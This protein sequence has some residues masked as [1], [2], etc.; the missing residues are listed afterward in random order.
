MKQMH[1]F[2]ITCLVTIGVVLTSPAASDA[3]AIGRPPAI[4]DEMMEEQHIQYQ[5]YATYVS[6]SLYAQMK[7]LEE[8]ENK[9]FDWVKSIADLSSTLFSQA[10]SLNSVLN[11]DF[12]NKELITLAIGTEL[13]FLNTMVGNEISGI[14]LDTA[15]AAF[16]THQGDLSAFAAYFSTQ[17][18][19]YTVNVYGAIQFWELRRKIDQATALNDLM[20]NYYAFGQDLDAIIDYYDIPGSGW[21]GIVQ[22]VS[23]EMDVDKDELYDDVLLVLR[24]MKDFYE[25][26][27]HYNENTPSAPGFYQVPDGINPSGVRF[28][29]GASSCEKCGTVKYNLEIH[30]NNRVI[31][32]ADE[33]LGHLIQRTSFT[34]PITLA[35]NTIYDWAVFPKSQSGNWNLEIGDFSRFT[36]GGSTANHLPSAAFFVSPAMGDPSTIFSFDASDSR[37][38]DGDSLSYQWRW[39]T[40]DGFVTSGMTATH[41]YAVPG[42]YTVTLRVSD[43]TADSYFSRNI[44][45]T[46]PQTPPLAPIDPNPGRGAVHQPIEKSITWSD[47][48][49]ADTYAVYFGTDTD[50]DNN[51]KTAVSNSFFDP[52]PLA[53]NTTYFWRVDA[54]NAHGTTLGDTWYFTTQSPPAWLF[55]HYWDFDTSGTEGWTPRNAQSQGIYNQDYWIIDPSFDPASKSGI[56]SAPDLKSLHTGQYGKIEVRAAV[57]NTYLDRLEAHLKIDD[58]WQPPFVLNYVSGRQTANSQCLYQGDIPYAGAIQQVRIDFVTGSD[59][60]DD[61]VYID[62]V[63]F[64]ERP[65]PLMHAISGYVTNEAGEGIPGVNMAFSNGAGTVLTN[66]AGYYDQN[67][68]EGWSGTV[69]P[70][71]P[72]Y[73]FNPATTDYNNVLFPQTKNYTGATTADITSKIFFSGTDTL[74]DGV[75]FNHGFQ[76]YSEIQAASAGN[77][78]TIPER[79]IL[80]TAGQDRADSGEY[81]VYRTTIPFDTSSLPE[82]AVITSAT[83]YLYGYDEGY[84][85]TDFDLQVVQAHPASHA[86]LVTADYSQFGAIPGGTLN[87]ATWQGHNGVNPIRLNHEGI[88]WINT[89]GITNLGLRSNRDINQ[90][91]PEEHG[92]VNFWS[93]QS[94]TDYR[95]VLAVE[96]EAPVVNAPEGIQGR[97]LD[98]RTQ[99]TIANAQVTAGSM[100]VQSNDNGQYLLDLG[101]GEYDVTVSR[102]G[103]QTITRTN[104]QVPDNTMVP[105]DIELPVSLYGI[106]T[107]QITAEPVMNVDI[108]ASSQTTKSNIRG[109]YTLGSLVPGIY[110]ILFDKYDHLPVTIPDVEIIA[111]QS[112]ELNVELPVALAGTVTDYA[113][114]QPISNVI[115]STINGKSTQTNPRGRYG[116]GAFSPGVYDITFAKTGYQTVTIENVY[117]SG[118][119]PVIRDMRMTLPGPL[120]IITPELPAAETQNPYNPLVRISGGTPPYTFTLSAGKIPPGCTLDA[121][122]GNITGIP[123]TPG[124]YTFSIRVMDA[125]GAYAERQ[126]SIEVTRPLV[127]ETDARLPDATQD[128]LYQTGI[129]ASGGTRPYHF[130]YTGDLPLDLYFTDTGN[131]RYKVSDTVDFNSNVLHQLWDVSPGVGIS[132]NKLNFNGAHSTTFAQIRLYCP[133]P[134]TI[135]FDYV[136]DF[137]AGYHITGTFAFFI[138]QVKITDWGKSH[139]GRYTA[140]VSAGWH[141]FM[142]RL[143]SER[144]NQFVTLDNITFPVNLEGNHGFMVT[145]TDT[146]GRDV[147]AQFQLRVLKKLDITTDQLD[148]GIVGTVYNQQITAVG[149]TGRYTWAVYA[150][151]LPDG[152]TLDPDSGALCGTPAET[153]FGTVVL[154]VTDENG[155]TAYKDLILHVEN[156]LNIATPS[157]P[158]GLTGTFY[159]EAIQVNGGILPCAFSYYGMLPDGLSLDPD[160]G[161]ISGTPTHA[162]YF[163]IIIIATDSSRPVSQSM[164]RSLGIDITGDL[165]IT[166]PAVLP[167]ERLGNPVSPVVLNAGGG[168]SPHVWQIVDGTLPEGI[169]LDPDTGEISGTPLDKGGFRGTLQVTDALD[170]TAVKTFFWHIADDLVIETGALP[171]GAVGAAYNFTLAAK[172]GEK[173]YEWRIKS[174]TLPDGLSLNRHTGT[175]SGEPAA[176]QTFSFTVEAS[177]SASPMQITEKTYTMQTLDDLLIFTPFLPKGRL[178]AAYT[179]T[180]FAAAGAPPYHWRLESGVLPPGLVLESR[181]NQAV[182]SGEPIQEG[183]WIFT[184]AV[185]DAGTPEVTVFKEFRVDIAGDLHLETPALASAE[186]GKPY[187]AMISAIGGDPPYT[188]QIVGGRLP[189]G[190]TMNS[191]T[192]HISGITNLSTGQSAAFTVKITDSG[193]PAISLEQEYAIGVADPLII[194]TDQLQKGLQK[195]PLQADFEAEGGIAPYTWSIAGGSLPSG[196]GLETAAGKLSGI[197]AECGIFDFALNLADDAGVTNSVTKAFQLEMICSNDYQIT[198]NIGGL[199][200][201]TVTLGGDG[202]GTTVTDE[203]GNFTFEH[204]A[205][206]NYTLTPYFPG[207]WFNP[208]VMTLEGLKLDMSGLGFEARDVFAGDVNGSGTIDLQDLIMVLEIVTGQ[209]PYHTVYPGADVDGDGRIGLPE[210]LYI[211]DKTGGNQHPDKNE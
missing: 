52:G 99:Q 29:W 141:D 42:R 178:N 6:P 112:L 144:S 166:T 174:G 85:H 199:A 35:P 160:T 27:I 126:Y 137:V 72:L 110:N 2:F 173:P 180:V 93:S 168:P 171:D 95:P 24:Y 119:T 54:I 80:L 41:Q 210:A 138:D 33:D 165:T 147:S 60:L 108:S 51:P 177:D 164:I 129:T 107:D 105:L 186:R 134:G 76:T 88:S 84:S 190:L 79:T 146:G 19:R 21:Q 159:S 13:D 22:Y 111:G 39:G 167:R 18:V 204:L 67:V 45:V 149:G 155:T 117:I 12:T 58:T 169:V 205:V 194:V 184:L 92:F 116:F 175:L 123:D 145:V 62:R 90:I 23:D 206:G 17:L 142:W 124:T 203:D 61:R 157:M 40:G 56:I 16:K 96:Y 59:T 53:Y 63:T 122:Y 3:K 195:A 94:A 34:L 163:N 44:T 66:S 87:T 202:S 101:P 103:Y 208:A 109:V 183:V 20:Y 152:M 191:T 172:G 69:T 209:I 47:G 5:L 57:K 9:N 133:E 26:F 170:H 73:A 196:L 98:Q 86:A 131:I 132:G 154:S 91:A 31:F 64:I 193:H 74:N 7:I 188:W 161:I 150:G 189:A 49:R 182:L 50:P 11:S 15:M 30:Q 55:Y 151:T 185:T 114:G 153:A 136:T 83:L 198:G 179:A 68:P 28:S 102:T 75:V 89:S 125:L 36:T 128:Q 192:G 162:G 139:A 140:G 71:K 135:S 48:G 32:K 43:G 115:V 176:I 120:N 200:G 197:P 100:S 201:V 187:S 130:S 118:T 106:V 8:R 81:Y 25:R 158:D 65:E 70:S 10:L 156:P 121:V 148:N 113:T 207:Y 127:I 104:I 181:M 1:Q 78:V 143:D 82:N 4:F 38:P 14:V 46:Q 77:H 211:L 37:D 97:I